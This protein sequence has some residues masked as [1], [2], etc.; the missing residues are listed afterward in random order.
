MR[1]IRVLIA[2]DHPLVREG[3]RAALSDE[4][5]VVVCGS[6]EDGQAAVE[7]CRELDPDIVLMDL[8]MPHVDGVAALRTIVEENPHMHVL[9]VSAYGDRAHVRAAMAAG[10]CGY[11]LKGTPAE[12]LAE[13]MR[14]VRRGE[15][16]MSPPELSGLV[17]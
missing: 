13:A 6:A 1:V 2:D 10:A 5:D 4:E 12:E 7:L 8:T 3:L 16:V 17:R 15:T 9:V 14:A 11:V